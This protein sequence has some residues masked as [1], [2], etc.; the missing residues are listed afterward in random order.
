MIVDNLGRSSFGSERLGFGI[1]IDFNREEGDPS[2]IFI[3][4]T[5]L[6]KAC[7]E[8]DRKLLQSIQVKVEHALILEDI[9]RGSLVAWFKNKFNLSQDTP[10]L[11]LSSEYLSSYLTESK[12]TL[13]D[14]TSNKT[15]IT[16]SGVSE[17]QTKIF[18]ILQ[19]EN[20][21]PILP[22]YNPLPKKDLLSGMQKIQSAL[23]T[24][25]DSADSAEYIDPHHGKASFNLSLDITQ[26]LIEEILVKETVEN[27]N[28]MI[29]KIKKP[30]YL[31]DSQWEF[32]YGK[33]NINVKMADIEWLRKFHKP[34][35]V[36]APGD[37]VRAS[38]KIITKYDIDNEILF[39]Q[40]I[41][42]EV[43]EIIHS[44]DF[45][46]LTILGNN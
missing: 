17:V 20:P 37:S 28:E 12:F 45:S 25:L 1:K 46:Q 40:Y 30:D 9:E 3:A 29:L 15:T 43:T 16:D 23:S 10:E 13:I 22:I 38:T 19:K 18:E 2:R 24:L 5:E 35:F 31:G 41:L 11:G 36:L 44:S 7:Q 42:L 32:K 39:V 4:M 6:V 27:T 8:I 14:Y 33:K 21:T 34:E 26:E